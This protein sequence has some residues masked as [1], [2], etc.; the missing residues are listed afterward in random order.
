MNSLEGCRMEWTWFH[1]NPRIVKEE[2]QCLCGARTHKLTSS[3]E[4]E[5]SVLNMQ[6]ERLLGKN[7]EWAY[8][9]RN[10]IDRKYDKLMNVIQCPLN[11]F[12][13]QIR[14]IPAFPLKHGDIY[15][16]QNGTRLLIE[17][18]GICP[19]VWQLHNLDQVPQHMITDN[20]HIRTNVACFG[21]L[22][23]HVVASSKKEIARYEEKRQYQAKTFEFV[24]LIFMCLGLYRDLRIKIAQL[25][26]YPR[27]FN[28]P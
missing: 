5:L 26:F 24:L 4:E 7:P 28:A 13:V 11:K 15:C 16:K 2:E 25:V 27:I 22:A 23:M 21:T 6:S 1:T 10:T 9:E 14:G 19:S 8:I 17:Q 12:S 20:I 3:Q 18:V